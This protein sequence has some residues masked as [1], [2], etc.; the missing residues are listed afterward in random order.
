MKKLMM[1]AGLA[2]AVAGCCT[3]CKEPACEKPACCAKKTC[4]A[5]KSWRELAEKL[6]AHEPPFA[7]SSV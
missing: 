2:L 6:L 1:V 7:V 4:C 3:T 5:Q